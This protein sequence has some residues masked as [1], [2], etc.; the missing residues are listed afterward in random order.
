MREDTCRVAT[1]AGCGFP[2]LF[3]GTFIEGVHI[4]AGFLNHCIR[5][6]FLFGGT[7]IEGSEPPFFISAASKFPFL[8][9]GTFIEGFWFGNI[10]AGGG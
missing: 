8:F 6:P 3:G 10:G 4:N 5:F 2:F 9:G 7:F 1:F